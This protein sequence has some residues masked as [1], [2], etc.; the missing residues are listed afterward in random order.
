MQ[1]LS[2]LLWFGLLLCG[3]GCTTVQ[4]ASHGLDLMPRTFES[5]GAWNFDTLVID[6]SQSIQ[7]GMRTRKVYLLY[8]FPNYAWHAVRLY[9]SGAPR[10]TFVKKAQYFCEFYIPVTDGVQRGWR[11]EKDEAC[12]KWNDMYEILGPALKDTPYAIE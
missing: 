8:S 10:G 1:L 5:I 3:V 2:R 6:D 11:K 9:E 12:E 7:K 4:P